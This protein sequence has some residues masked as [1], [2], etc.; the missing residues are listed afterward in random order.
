MSSKEPARA[1]GKAIVGATLATAA[2]RFRDREAFYCATT[3][4]RFT[5]RQ[6]NERCN[7]LAHGLAALGLKKPDP[8]AF[9][10]NNRAELPEIYYAL[11]KS[12]LVGIPLNYRLA[13]AEI[14]ALMRA[15]SAR[16]LLFET[17]FVAA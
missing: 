12:G 8:V 2:R 4:R 5:F 15:M 7:R 11:A 9:L 16:A 3:D 13:P 1:L 14:V 6:T 10:C 17:R